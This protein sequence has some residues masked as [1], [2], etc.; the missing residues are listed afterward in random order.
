MPV[1]DQY[2]RIRYIDQ[3]FGAAQNGLTAKQILEI[4]NQRLEVNEKISLRTL[5]NDIAALKEGLFGSQV[6]I[7]EERRGRYIY[8][9]YQDPN[10]SLYTFQLSAAEMQQVRQAMSLLERSGQYFVEI[11]QL[12]RKLNPLDGEISPLEFDDNPD[13]MGLAWM[14]IITEAINRN[15]CLTII[16]KPFEKEAYNVIIHPYRLREYNNRWYVTGLAEP[17]NQP[18]HQTV[19]ALDRIEH[20][21]ANTDAAYNREAYDPEYFEDVIGITVNHNEPVTRI[22]LRVEAYRAEYIRTKPLHRTQRGPHA[23]DNG[24]QEFT[25]DVR[26]NRELVSTILSFGDDVHVLEPERLRLEVAQRYLSAISLY[27]N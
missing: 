2:K 19:L 8:Y 24:W 11:E 10:F 9:R 25:I 7:Y 6:L 16:Y 13:Y 5:Q 14:P 15:K 18:Y 20:I 27:Q 21:E 26:H 22:R 12:K 4:L 23:T 17:A 3:I 1:I